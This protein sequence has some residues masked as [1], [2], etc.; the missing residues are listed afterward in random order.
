MLTINTWCWY[1]TRFSDKTESRGKHVPNYS[2]CCKTVSDTGTNILIFSGTN[3][4][5]VRKE[6][7]LQ[8][9]LQRH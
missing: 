3:Y 5:R 8:L 1:E 4:G 7:N 9:Y 6:G 2:N